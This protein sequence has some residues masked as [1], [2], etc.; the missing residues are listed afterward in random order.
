MKKKRF[1]IIDFDSGFY[2]FGNIFRVLILIGLPF[3]FIVFLYFKFYDNPKQN[4][5]KIAYRESFI[6]DA[7]Y[8]DVVIGKNEDIN[9]IEYKDTF[10]QNKYDSDLYN[11]VEKGDSV[12]KEKGN[13]F[14]TVKRQD[15]TF[16]V[17]F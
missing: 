16:I 11:V 1:V 2:S 7:S 6:Q 3:L 4:R 12:I 9:L 5:E 17:E 13:A 14:Y 8:K 10:F 15:S